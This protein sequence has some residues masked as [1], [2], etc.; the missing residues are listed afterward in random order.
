MTALRISRAAALVVMF[1]ALGAGALEAAD[2]AATA[3]PALSSTK[4]RGM[5][6]ISPDAALSQGRLV[7]RVVAFNRTR[8]PAVFSDADVKILTAAGKPVGIV[9]LERLI[10]EVSRGAARGTSVEHNPADYSHPGIPTTGTGGAGEPELGGYT[11]TVN[12]TSGVVSTH[13][14]V[15]AADST[16][17]AQS[18]Q[19]ITSLKA[20]ILQ[21]T[22]IPSAGVAGG[23]VVTE[24]LRFARKET[25]SLRVLVD[26]NG[27]QHEFSL[28]VPAK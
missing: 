1:A 16:L 20:G 14:R 28:E 6:S 4:E 5:I 3:P 26:F 2:T 13:T 23:Q 7:L 18:Q 12:P 15:S 10:A 19:Q 11:G 17:D 21:P 8:E 27:E 25:R 9:P 24:K 22:I